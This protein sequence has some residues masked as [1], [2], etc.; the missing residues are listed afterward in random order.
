LFC[1]S[2]YKLLN[3]KWIHYSSIRERMDFGFKK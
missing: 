3:K 2:F 1:L